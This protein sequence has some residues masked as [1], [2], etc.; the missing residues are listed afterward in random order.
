MKL[1]NTYSRSKERFLPKGKTVGFY[2]CGPTV[3]APPHIGNYR[4]YVW[5]DVIRRYLGHCGWKIR[6][7]MNITDLD[8]IVLREAKKKGVGWKRLARKYEKVFLK[9]KRSLGCL[10]A[11]AYPRASEHVLGMARLAQKLLRKGHAYKDEKG[12][13]YFDISKFGLYGKLSHFSPVM[14][15]KKK[16]SRQDYW[17]HEAGDFILWIKCR[18]N[19]SGACWN[20]PLGYGR[21]A[22]NIECPAMSMKY[23]GEEFDIHMGGTDNVF[24]HHE[25]EIAVAKC[26][27]GKGFVRYWMHVKHLL[28]NG[29]K[30][31]KSKGNVIVLADLLQRGYSAR[32]VRAA[33]L[34]VH[35]RRRMNFTLA[36]MERIAQYVRRVGTALRRVEKAAQKGAYAENARELAAAKR[37]GK[38][39]LECFEYNMNDD[40]NAPHVMLHCCNL[41]CWADGK[42]K[43]RKLGRKSALLVLKTVREMNSVL[44]VLEI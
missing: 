25:N 11:Q 9:E 13:V 7:V 20:T 4:T 26:A 19:G 18:A 43:I 21:P 41:V 35:Y 38:D 16:I 44:N 15:A 2:T 34:S 10:D 37:K 8:D 1:F 14:K 39:A 23:L 29:K 42:A 30:M 28:L 27:T 31:S 17:Q 5:E 36:R 33:L 24:S 3:Y 12:D 32:E 6:H 40:F 22:W